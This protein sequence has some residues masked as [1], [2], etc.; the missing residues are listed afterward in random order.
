[1]DGKNISVKAYLQS[2]EGGQEIRRF[3]LDASAATSFSYLQGKLRMVFPSLLRRP[4]DVRW[5]DADG[6][7]ITVGSDEELLVALVNLLQVGGQQTLRLHVAPSRPCRAAPPADGPVHSGVCC[8][9]CEQTIRG[10]RYK[11]MTCEDFDLCATCEALCLHPEH[12]MLRIPTPDRV[13]QPVFRQAQRFNNR[14][15]HFPAAWGGPFGMPGGPHCGRFERRAE[16]AEHKAEKRAEKAEHRAEK[17]AERAEKRAERQAERGAQQGAAAAE[18]GATAAP[19]PNNFFEAIH[20][21]M[22][23]LGGYAPEGAAAQGVPAGRW[24]EKSLEELGQTIAACLDPFG[25]DVD[26]GVE[27]RQKRTEEASGQ[28]RPGASAARS[29]SAQDI[30]AAA[31]NAAKAATAAAAAAAARAASA[32]TAATANYIANAANAAAAATAPAPAAASAPAAPAPAPEATLA[33]AASAPAPAEMDAEPVAVSDGVPS[34]TEPAAAAPA[35]TVIPVTVEDMPNDPADDWTMVSG[36]STP[37][38]ASS[39]ARSRVYPNLAA[40][41]PTVTSPA[42][43]PPTAATP[44][45][46]PPP[47]AT[48]SQTP[49]PAATPVPAAAAAAGPSAPEPEPATPL[50]PRV[51]RALDAMSAMGFSNDGGWL[52]QLLQAK[53]GDIS[54]VLDLLQPVP[55]RGQ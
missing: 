39:G 12:L 33:P 17:R 6:D 32:A 10:H 19:Q 13:W 52:T 53:N 31:T 29:P 55:R 4:F 25:I 18:G 40:E 11:C 46:T 36:S 23:A 51:Q 28:Q 27:T 35:E 3:G 15:G 21:A 41:A 37:S 9:G 43:T 30:A 49:P 8:D 24:T 48:P 45:Q 16:K 26:V 7:S 54:A 42:Q 38:E 1:M 47:A 2:D 20:S 44:T 14:R 34:Q 5:E 22:S 50:E